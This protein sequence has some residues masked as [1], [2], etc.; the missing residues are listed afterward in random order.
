MHTSYYGEY[1]GCDTEMNGANGDSDGHHICLSE[2]HGMHCLWECT[3]VGMLHAP[4]SSQTPLATEFCGIHTL[5]VCPMS[6]LTN[7]TSSFVCLLHQTII[8]A[9]CIFLS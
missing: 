9:T 8:L 5:V 6:A 4:R 7:V 1:N 3:L 2:S